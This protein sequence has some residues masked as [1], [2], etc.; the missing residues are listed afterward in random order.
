MHPAFMLTNT[1]I[2]KSLGKIVSPEA[3]TWLWYHLTKALDHFTFTLILMFISLFCDELDHT[4]S[5]TPSLALRQ[6]FLSSSFADVRGFWHL[7]PQELS[8]PSQVAY[9]PRAGARLKGEC[10]VKAGWW[11]STTARRWR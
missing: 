7:Q 4:W 3:L 6:V 10:L 8:V 2:P 9:K 1:Y 5:S 11:C